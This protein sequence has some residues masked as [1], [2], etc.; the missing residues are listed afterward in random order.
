TQQASS[1]SSSMK[2][3]SVSSKERSGRIV[4]QPKSAGRGKCWFAERVADVVDASSALV[5]LVDK[6]SHQSAQHVGALR[7][8]GDA[9]VICRLDEGN[10]ERDQELLGLFHR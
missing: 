1:T 4:I 7:P 5:E 3:R 6:N 8:V 9:F 2:W 10:F